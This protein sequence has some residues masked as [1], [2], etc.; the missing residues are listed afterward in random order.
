MSGPKISEMIKKMKI[1]EVEKQTGISQR[2]IRHYE[3]M[4]LFF[5][6]RMGSYRHYGEEEI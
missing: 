3:E 4:G 1:G 5:P 6:E 2:M